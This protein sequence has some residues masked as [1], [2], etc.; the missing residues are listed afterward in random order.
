MLNLLE[1]GRDNDGLMVQLACIILTHACIGPMN[2]ALDQESYDEYGIE[3]FWVDV[4][5][6]RIVNRGVVYEL[7]ATKIETKEIV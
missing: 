4:D 5:K 2:N 6:F 1:E 7:R 3:E